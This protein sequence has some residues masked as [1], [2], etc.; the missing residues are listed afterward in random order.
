MQIPEA[1]EKLKMGKNLERREAH[2]VMEEV[3]SGR[4]PDEQIVAL[5]LAEGKLFAFDLNDP[6]GNSSCVT[7]G[8]CVQACPTG[9]L[10]PAREAGRAKGDQAVEARCPFC[11]VGCQLTYTVGDN[12]KRVVSGRDGPATHGRLCVKGRSGFAY[13]HLPHRLTTPLI[14]KEGVAKGA[15]F[16]VDPANWSEVFREAVR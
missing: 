10:M 3:L 6:M 8:E 1:I 14:R 2:A 16:V 15:D 9:A 4:A 7:C 11:G 13:A 12:K 5:L